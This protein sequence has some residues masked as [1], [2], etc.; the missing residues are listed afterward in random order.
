MLVFSQ[1]DR[2]IVK[3]KTHLLS[4]FLVAVGFTFLY[5]GWK[6]FD[7]T[8][9]YGETIHRSELFEYIRKQNQRHGAIE[10]RIKTLESNAEYKIIS[11]TRGSFDF[12]SFIH[13]VEKGDQLKISLVNDNHPAEIAQIS[14]QGKAYIHEAHR[15]ASRKGNGLFGILGGGIFVISGI[16]IYVKIRRNNT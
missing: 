8:H 12:E 5:F 13:D 16:W 15:N 10:Y 14:H 3:M 1:F 6:Q 7:A 11:I 2:V 4:F 9:F